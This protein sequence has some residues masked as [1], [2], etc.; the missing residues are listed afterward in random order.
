[1]NCLSFV[2]NVPV[3][4]PGMSDADTAWLFTTAMQNLASRTPEL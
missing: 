3:Q 4:Q 2:W 1:M